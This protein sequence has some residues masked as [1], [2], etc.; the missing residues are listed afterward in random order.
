MLYVSGNYKLLNNKY[1]IKNLDDLQ[2]LQ[3]THHNA[4]VIY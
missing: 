1:L 3:W 2:K 4:W